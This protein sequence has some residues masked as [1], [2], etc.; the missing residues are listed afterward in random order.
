[1]T[2]T[3]PPDGSRLHYGPGQREGGEGEV[4]AVAEAGGREHTAAGD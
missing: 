3:S 2:A 4:V 1:M